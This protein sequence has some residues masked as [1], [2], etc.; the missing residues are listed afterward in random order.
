MKWI[1]EI[2]RYSKVKNSFVLYG[3][4]YDI[5]GYESEGRVLPL[6]MD[7]YLSR[8]LREKEELKL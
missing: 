5:F 2:A 6:G 4:I 8:Y 7:K 1:K 3:N